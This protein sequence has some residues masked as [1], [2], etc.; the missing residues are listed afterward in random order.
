MTKQTPKMRGMIRL[1]TVAALAFALAGAPAGAQKRDG[2]HASQ[3]HNT[4]R[5]AHS[6]S[7][8]QLSPKTASL[9]G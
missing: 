7:S 8:H 6:H 1:A 4:S 5:R 2:G 9:N 3:Q